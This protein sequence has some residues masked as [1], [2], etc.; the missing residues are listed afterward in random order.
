M[1]FNVGQKVKHAADNRLFENTG[2]I[3]AKGIFVD[4]KGQE[5]EVYNVSFPSVGR[6]GAERHILLG[7]EL[8]SAEESDLF[9]TGKKA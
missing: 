5:E 4:K 3:L 6:I 9:E 1:K 7:D 8:Q 2:I